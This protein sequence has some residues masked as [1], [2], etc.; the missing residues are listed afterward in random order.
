MAFRFHRRIR[1]MPGVTINLGK[2]GISTSIGPRGA[3]IT[4]G[5][6]GVRSTVGIPGTG[7][8]YTKYRSYKTAAGGKSFISVCPY[9]GHHMRKFWTN[10]PNCGADLLHEPEPLP[11]PATLRCPKCGSVWV[12]NGQIHFCP[13]CGAPIERPATS[14]SPAV[15]DATTPKQES[16]FEIFGITMK[17]ILLLVGIMGFVIIMCSL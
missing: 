13:N 9:C 5:S 4:I 3:K 2:R 11:Q 14:P 17:T 1:I 10:C 8:S 12:D 6:K 7:I 16:G 15:S